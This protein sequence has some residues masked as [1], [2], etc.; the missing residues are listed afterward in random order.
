[1]ALINTSVPNLIQGVSQ[2]PD[3]TRFDGQCEEQE[4]ALS[5]VAEGLKKRPNTRHIARLLTSAISSNAKVHF[6]NR[7]ENERYVAI[8]D[9]TLRI[10]NLDTG[11]EATITDDTAPAMSL[12]NIWSDGVSPASTVNSFEVFQQSS[13]A[14]ESYDSLEAVNSTGYGLA[15]MEILD[16]LSAG[17]V[18]VVSFYVDEIV[19]NNWTTDIRRVNINGSS[20]INDTDESPASITT[21]GQKTFTFTIT[22]NTGN[23]APSIFLHTPDIN[24]SIKIRGLKVKAGQSLSTYLTSDVTNPRE[25]LDFLTVADYTF[26]VNKQKTVQQNA[27]QTPD[28]SSAAVVFI[29]QIGYKTSYTVG[30]NLGTVAAITGTSDVAENANVG[31]NNQITTAHGNDALNVSQVIEGQS[32]HNGYFQIL[33]GLAPRLNTLDGISSYAI[34]GKSLTVSGHS[35]I[36]VSDSLSSEGIGLVWKTVDSIT[37]LPLFAILGL[38]VKVAGD[39]ELNQD[40]YYVRFQT[41]SGGSSGRGYWEETASPNISV[42]L[43]GQTMPHQLINTGTNTFV[44]QTMTLDE[45]SAGDDDTNP[46]PSFVGKKLRSVFFFKNRLGFVTGDSVVMSEAGHFFN[47][48]RKTVTTLL[49]DAPIDIN[50]SSTKVTNLKSAVGFQGNLMLFADNQQFVLRGGDI[51]T[52]KTVS[53]S[54]ATSYDV[55]DSVKPLALGSYIYFPF[56]RGTYTG[57]RELAVDASTDNFDAV[58]ITEHVPAYVPKDIIAMSGTSSEDIIALLSNDEKG[59]LY[60]YNYFWNNNQKVLSAWSKFTFTGEIRGIEFIGSTLY[61]VI[62]NNGETNL[63][64]MPLESGLKDDTGFVT[65]LDMRVAN[66]VLSGNDVINLPYTPEDD[67]VEVYTTDGLALGCSNVGSVVTL[68]SPVASDTDVWVGTPYTMKYTF[69]EQLFKAQAGNGKSPSN[70]AKMMIRNGSV[71][72]D[73]SSFFKVKVTPKFRD[74]YEN[75]FTPDVVGSTTLG[76]LNLDSGFYRFPVFTKPEDTTITIENDSAL[77]STFQSAEFE[78]FVHSRSNRYG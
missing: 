66:T 4:N 34:G 27:A 28:Y 62:V 70:A 40:D 38:V 56:T 71:Y 7:T 61:A 15:N 31:W 24:T 5:S 76:S 74:T 59:S 16:S 33:A 19:G 46:H 6:I 35:T 32:Y 48:Y 13:E 77:P 72:Y 73:K 22:G 49:D 25:D 37:D 69:S 12:S 52:A 39:T 63:V 17:D 75:V 23:G 2:Q 18:V 26:C 47:F 53:V 60:I 51:L 44:L 10:F 64:E 14:G 20:F 78:S 29:K 45:R 42:G 67:S 65:H 58:E 50:V 55:E 30:T 11:V 3:A 9:G 36:E 43:D 1:M 57:V 68:S 41:N 8:H 21:T 54:P